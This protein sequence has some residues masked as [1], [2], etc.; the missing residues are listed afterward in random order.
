M[1]SAVP[2][3]IRRSISLHM[4]FSSMATT[5]FEEAEALK[6]IYGDDLVIRSNNEFNVELPRNC[7]AMVSN[8]SGNLPQFVVTWIGISNNEDGGPLLRP[9]AE[10]IARAQAVALEEIVRL[11]GE[12]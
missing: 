2:I 7:V 1:Y 5:F 10:I 8:G 4:R 9:A 3:A 11:N 12:D 6:A